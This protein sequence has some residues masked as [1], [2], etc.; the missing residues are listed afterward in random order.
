VER[1]IREIHVLQRKQ[2]KPGVTLGKTTGWIHRLE[3]KKNGVKFRVGVEYVSID[4]SG[5]WI[6]QGDKDILVGVDTVVICAG[7]VSEPGLMAELD[8]AGVK[9]HVI[10]GAE[11]A[12]ELDAKKA[13]ADGVAIADSL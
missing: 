8:T 5:L 2:S 6:N 11:K 10:G 12:A 4:E 13:I 9:Y 1:P 3:L 7:Q